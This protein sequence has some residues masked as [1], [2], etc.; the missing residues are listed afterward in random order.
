M[1]E[2]YSKSELEDFCL[3]RCLKNNTLILLMNFL[4][5]NY[6]FGKKQKTIYENSMLAIIN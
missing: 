2:K 3:F 1:H 4:K 5:H 6:F